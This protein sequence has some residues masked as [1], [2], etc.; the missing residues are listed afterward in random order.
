MPHDFIIPAH[1]MFQGD[2]H[3]T[4]DSLEEAIDHVQGTADYPEE[5]EYI[6]G[7]LQLADPEVLQEL[8]EASME[9]CKIDD[10]PTSDLPL[11]IGSLKTEEGKQHLEE[12]IRNN[13]A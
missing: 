5:Y 1:W 3:V 8:N 12:R 2:Y 11:L 4:A 9:L 10:T 13:V 7:S 6:D